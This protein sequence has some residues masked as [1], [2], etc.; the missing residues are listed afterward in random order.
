MEEL[1]EQKEVINDLMD[2][3]T[4]KSIEVSDLK[5]RH[6]DEI[7]ELHKQLDEAYAMVS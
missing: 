1:E 2:Q 4:K 7:K 3:L 5:R 6:E